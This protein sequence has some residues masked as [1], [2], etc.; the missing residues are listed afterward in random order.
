MCDT[1]GCTISSANAHLI[2]A[3]GKL[4]HTHDGQVSVEVL[5]SLLH[6]NDHQA[7]HNREHFDRHG[8]LAINL[9]SSPGSG[10]TSLLEATIDALGDEIGIAVVLGGDGVGTGSERG[11]TE[12]GHTSRQGAGAEGHGAVFEGYRPSWRSRTRSDR[13]GEDHRLSEGGGILGR[14]NRGCRC[15]LVHG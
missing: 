9:M 11:S 6:E 1:C 14:S 5:S 8:V 2:E 3:G 13:G 10:K 15:S 12:R 4:Q 7:H